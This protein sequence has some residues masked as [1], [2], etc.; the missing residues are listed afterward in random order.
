VVCVTGVSAFPST[1]YFQLVCTPGSALNLKAIVRCLGST[2]DLVNLTGHSDHT[3]KSGFCP[4]PQTRGFLLLNLFKVVQHFPNYFILSKML[5]KRFGQTCRMSQGYKRYS[6]AG[7][8][9]NSQWLSQ[10]RIQNRLISH[11]GST[12]QQPKCKSVSH[13]NS[14]KPT[15]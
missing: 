2:A 8:G 14:I 11:E 5:S 7:L 13:Q 12:K 15:L 10:T 1:S 9:W 3:Q 4:K 6:A